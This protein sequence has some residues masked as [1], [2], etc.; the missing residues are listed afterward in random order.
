MGVDARGFPGGLLRLDP[1]F[2]YVEPPSSWPLPWVECLTLAPNTHL[3]QLLWEKRD[4]SEPP[5]ASCWRVT[6]RSLEPGRP[7]P[8]R[9]GAC[10]ALWLGP[11]APPTP[12]PAPTARIQL[13]APLP[14]V[15]AL[16]TVDSLTKTLSGVTWRKPGASTLS[17]GH[18]VVSLLAEL[19]HGT[20]HSW[21]PRSALIGWHSLL[22]YL[23]GL[24]R[25]RGQGRP[26]PTRALT[27]GRGAPSFL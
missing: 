9:D 1:A 15:T 11:G 13:Q 14:L 20:P 27:S 8:H 7:G 21:A 10:G 6:E 19:P 25:T 23:G 12:V 5:R 26:S 2:A 24:P 3:P 16:A 18:T 22:L 17:C 4:S